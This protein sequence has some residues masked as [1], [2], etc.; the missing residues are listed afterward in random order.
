MPGPRWWAGFVVL[1]AA[2]AAPAEESPP[3]R[4]LPPGAVARLGHTRLRHADKVTCVAFAPDGKTF[5]TGGADGTVRVWSVETGEQVNLLQKPG[6]AVSS[7]SFAR[8]GKQ[9]AVRFGSDGVV[10]F[11]DATTLKGAGSTPLAHR[12]HFVLSDDGKLVATTDFVG[13]TTVAEVGSGLPKLELTGASVAAFR[14][15][16]KVVAV[17]GASGTVTAHLV[18][19]GKPVFTAKHDGPIRGLAYSPDGKRL[20]VGS[21]AGKG[22]DLLRVYEPGR[23]RP[24]A[25]VA[26]VS[27]VRAWVGADA[28][29]CGNGAEAGVYDLAKKQWRARI[30]NAAGEFAVSPDGTMLAATGNGLRVRLWDLR[31]GKQLH[32]ED[33]TFPEPA[34]L[35]GSRDGRSLFLLSGEAA[36][37]WQVGAGG[38]KRA[39]TLPG[40][41]A[42]AA[43]GGDRLL[44]ATPDAVLL[45]EHFDPTKPL[46]AKPAV[47]FKG[48]AG[49]R[50]VAISADGSRAAWADSGGKVSV[51]GA[52]GR[53]ARRELP[54]T[55]STV[56]ALGLNPAGDRLAVLGRDPF[57]RVWDV[58]RDEPK[59]VWKARVPRGTRG[60]VTFS[61]DGKLVAAASTAQLLVFDAADGDDRGEA[62]GPLY[63]YQRYIDNGEVQHAAFGPDSRTLVVGTSGP[64]GRLEVWGVES[65]KLLRTFTTGYGGTSRLCLF[66]GGR[67]AAS[68]GAEEAVTVWDLTAGSE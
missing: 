34:L 21:S 30:K 68:A 26:G 36:Y 60:V 64:S 62:R 9:L 17:G 4:A 53:R 38:A 3:A 45:Y 39:G 7:V 16:G 5:V 44:V 67:R 40:R 31:T 29:A 15:D 2:G 35:A 58:S 66:P 12:H 27:V 55:T 6:Q 1:L 59:E 11:L 65:R 61:P 24:V 19:G 43:A 18:T 52:A 57:L 23:E 37:L 41:A 28:L 8:G 47:A 10:L 25:E 13:D 63:R 14:P 50:A 20:A 32:A 46:P 54:A 48:S 49:A 22:N 42:A 56:L 51:A 33:D